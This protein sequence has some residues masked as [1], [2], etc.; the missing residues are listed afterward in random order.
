[1]KYVGM[2]MGMWALFGASFE[3]NLTA[4]FGLNPETA[5]AVSEKQKGSTGRLFRDFRSL[6]GQTAFR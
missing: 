3:K 1:M 6:R 4:V 5:K 2:P